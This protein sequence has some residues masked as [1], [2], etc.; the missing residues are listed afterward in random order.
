MSGLQFKHEKNIVF[1]WNVLKEDVPV[2][3]T[4]EVYDYYI[5]HLNLVDDD[6]LTLY[7]LNYAYLTFMKRYI[8]EITFGK[9]EIEMV[10]KPPRRIQWGENQIQIVPNRYQLMEE[11]RHDQYIEYMRNRNRHIKY[12]RGI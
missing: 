10:K 3:K 8:A 5:N 9:R 6:D 11:Q 4:Q 2:H 12:S 7:Q 1:L